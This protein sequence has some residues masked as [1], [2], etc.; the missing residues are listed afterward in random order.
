M[1]D[2]GE[3]IRVAR[4]AVKATPEDHPDLAGRLNN[5]GV[6]LTRRYERTGQMEDLEEAIRVARQAWEC[7][8]A[9]PFI[10][11]RASFLAL[12]L[13]QNRGEFEEA[14]EF[15]KETIKLLPYVHNESLDH[16]DQQYVVSHFSGLA[17]AACSLA[18]QSGNSAEVALKILEQG[19]G[20]IL[21]LLMDD[22]S[23]TSRL[24]AAHPQLFA[25]YETLRIELNK[26]VEDVA[27]SHLREI[28][29]KRRTDVITELERCIQHIQQLPAFEGFH[30]G[31]TAKEMQDCSTKGSVIV[32]NI[33]DLRSDAII[34]T[35]NGLKAFSLSALCARQA[36][37]WI[38]QDLSTTSQSDRGRKNKAYLQFLSWLWR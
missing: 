15:S 18:L 27:D 31:L 19:R 16:Q 28:A 25:Q 37:D 26:P 21:G 1:E 36:K 35:T 3:A 22:R 33:T 4:Q 24:N 6:Q 14:Y 11:I 32:I 20:V 13:L 7:R 9:V 10:R 8:N 29:S 38:S 34:I 17:A 23:D 2:L 5:L 30:K 12:R